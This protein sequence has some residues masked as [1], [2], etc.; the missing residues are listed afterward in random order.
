MKKYIPLS[1]LLLALLLSA[2]GGKTNGNLKSEN[3]IQTDLE[4]SDYFWYLLAPQAQDEYNITDLVINSRITESEQSDTVAV[5]VTAES[6]Y[7]VYTG[8][9]S[10]KYLYHEDAGY[11]YDSVYQGFSGTYSDVKL[12]SD[13]FAKAYFELK[14]ASINGT[15]QTAEIEGIP[16]DDKI[17]KMNAVYESRDDAAHCTST[18]YA[19]AI[20]QFIG[21][22]W[23]KEGSNMGIKVTDE[24][25]V[26]DTVNEIYW[27][28]ESCAEGSEIELLNA[29][30]VDGHQYYDHF[31]YYSFADIDYKWIIK[32]GFIEKEEEMQEENCYMGCDG[33]G[34]LG[35]S[36]GPIDE[37]M[38]IN[39][40]EQI[41]NENSDILIILEPEQFL[42]DT[43]MFPDSV[44]IAKQYVDED[45]LQVA[46][47]A[48][49]GTVGYDEALK[50]REV[51]SEFSEN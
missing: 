1:A 14:M 29:Y 8:T 15:L 48:H 51:T 13:D 50:Q 19:Y 18:I 36:T 33:Y 43:L 22:T 26:Y 4:Q 23:Q 32:Y 10:V 21:G 11:V 16:S 44:I 7:A 40:F 5:T 28:K 38:A 3:E 45:G 34:Y 27:S 46:E 20:S 30:T 24:V 41:K 47:V 39:Y 31:V 35:E 6:E 17:C 9:F 2:C 49:K 12:P 42:L 37:Q 25:D